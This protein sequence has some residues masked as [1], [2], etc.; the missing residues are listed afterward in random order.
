LAFSLDFFGEWAHQP[1][2]GR[3]PPPIL[4]VTVHTP[5]VTAQSGQ[6]SIHR[7]TSHGRMYTA[8]TTLIVIPKESASVFRAKRRDRHGVLRSVKNCTKCL[9]PLREASRTVRSAFALAAVLTLGGCHSAYIAATISN[10]TPGALSLIEVDYPSASFGTQ[11]LAAGQDFHYR[12]KVLGSGPTAILWTDDAHQ[13][14]KNP[15]PTLREGDEGTLTVTFIPTGPTW[16][17]Q[18]INR[19][20]GS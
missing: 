16:S 3:A 5:P 2:R 19:A 13:D 7:R 11:T 4:P 17:L 9:L 6:C 18:L 8:R 12:F 1:R 10:R 20:A 14:H 15:G